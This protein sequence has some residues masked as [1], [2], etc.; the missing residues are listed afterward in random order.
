[1]D[2]KD[3]LIAMLEDMERDLKSIDKQDVFI[4]VACV[5]LVSLW[6]IGV[7]AEWW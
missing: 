4:A 6:I 2:K 7:I 3:L 5:A 1:M